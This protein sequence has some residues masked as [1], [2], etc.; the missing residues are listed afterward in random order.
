MGKNAINIRTQVSSAFERKSNQEGVKSTPINIFGVIDMQSLLSSIN[1]RFLIPLNV[2]NRGVA[3]MI[4]E[5]SCSDKR[6]FK[7]SV[8]P[9]A[10]E[11]IE[12]DGLLSIIIN[13]NLYSLLVSS[14]NCCDLFKDTIWNI[15]SVFNA[16]GRHKNLSCRFENRSFCIYFTFI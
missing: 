8:T 15:R 2:N 5:D 11:R 16:V 10:I 6:T 12:S 14:P 13:S 9:I 4:G 1:I 3:K 7:R